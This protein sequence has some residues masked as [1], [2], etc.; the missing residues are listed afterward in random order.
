[1]KKTEIIN[2]YRVTSIDGKVVERVL[3]NF[4]TMEPKVIVKCEVKDPKN[5]TVAERDKLLLTIAE[6]LDL[7]G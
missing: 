6:K 5:L 4:V 7:V 3:N 2:G 1:M